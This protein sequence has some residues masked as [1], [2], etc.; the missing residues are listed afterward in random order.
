MKDKIQQAQ[1]VAESI[2]SILGVDVYE[3][4]RT[5]PLVDARSMYCY[6]LRNDFGF[7]LFDVRDSL[8]AYGK[9]FNHC[10]VLHNVNLWPEVSNRRK[11]FNSIRMEILG[12]IDPK[13]T[14]ISYIQNITD[15]EKIN[16]I[17]NY[18]KEL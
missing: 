16:V 11:E 5:L 18:I 7:T 8:R 17:Y 13:N 12:H 4:K 14:I 2:K 3:N 15:I 9:K 10:T 6:I 1:E